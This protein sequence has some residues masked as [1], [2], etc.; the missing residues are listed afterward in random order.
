MNKFLRTLAAVVAATVIFAAVPSGCATSSA[1]VPSSVVV[2]DRGDHPVMATAIQPTAK[3]V[4]VPPS[5]P[6][7]VTSIM[8]LGDSLT[9]GSNSNNCFPA[10]A[11]NCAIN[12]GIGSDATSGYAD[13]LFDL[14]GQAGLTVVGP[15]GSGTDSQFF[16]GT[17]TAT[18]F[19]RLSR[20]HEG[21]NGFC[22]SAVG[23]FC[24]TASSIADQFATYWASAPASMVILMGG[25]N[26]LNNGATGA[27]AATSLAAALDAIYVTAPGIKILFV[28]PPAGSATSAKASAFKAAGDVVIGAR[29]A[30]GMKVWSVD[31]SA[32]NLLRDGNG[33]AAGAFFA[34]T[35]HPN[36]MGYR[37][38]A[39][40][41]FRALVACPYAS[42]DNGAT[43][44]DKYAANIWPRDEVADMRS[45]KSREARV[46]ERNHMT[47]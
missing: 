45:R 31:A 9:L 24:I 40:I 36:Y 35:I 13:T 32:T 17:Q 39:G 37:I 21:H 28:Y 25:S 29:V 19:N 5:L 2:A 7:S 14:I 18:T 47:A 44:A 22:L 10:T 6:G 33:G 43:S 1:P 11:N 27:Q 16:R 4:Y 42:N 41:I 46:F 26:D 20:K 8:L 12:L 30:A 23:G 3:K 15:L 38:L 34:D